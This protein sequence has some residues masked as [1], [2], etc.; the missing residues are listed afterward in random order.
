ML[1]CRGVKA[2]SLVKESA[3]SVLTL[4]RQ[5]ASTALRSTRAI[6]DAGNCFLRPY[7]HGAIFHL[8]RRGLSLPAQVRMFA[9][10]LFVRLRTRSEK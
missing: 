7:P 2:L 9:A 1:S 8:C 10:V 5:D 6:L 4:E 3:F